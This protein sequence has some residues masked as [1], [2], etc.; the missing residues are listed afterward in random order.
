[1]FWGL[2]PDVYNIFTNDTKSI[3]CFASP[4]NH[5]LNNYYSLLPIDKQFGSYGNFFDNFSKSDKTTYIMNPPFTEELISKLFDE[6]IKKLEK[7]I[8]CCIY[9]YIPKWDDLND[10]FHKKIA[11]KHKILKHILISN[12]SYVYNY[13]EEKRFVA[14]FDT[15]LYL[16]TNDVIENCKD[17]FQKIINFMTK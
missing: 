3:E 13:I 10:P 12:E 6:I 1:M 17:N 15:T 2:L 9:L 16:I 7:D 11:Q 8:K 4:F 14:K 5:T